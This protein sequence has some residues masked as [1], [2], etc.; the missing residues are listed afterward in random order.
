MGMMS[1]GGFRKMHKMSMVLILTIILTLTMAAGSM[2]AWQVNIEVSTPDPNS[3]TGIASNKLYIGTDV[4]ATAGYDNQLDTVALLRG[5]VQA[6]LSHPEYPSGQ[7]KL[8]RDVRSDSLPQDWEI[9][10]QSSGANNTINFNWKI[11]A[12]NDLS[13]I[14]IDNDSGQ[15]IDIAS[16]S[17]YSYSN[18]STTSK[19]FLLKVSQNLATSDQGSGGGSSKGGGCGYIKDF[20]KKNNSQNERGQVALNMIILMTPLLLPLRNYIRRYALAFGIG[21]T[22]PQ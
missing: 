1:N 3:D 2:A 14:L 19:K 16:S 9:E 20:G 6:Y 12:P 21:K 18:T 13:F 5:P 15:N 4:A 7:Q 22:I 17:G 11:V 10:V 8:W